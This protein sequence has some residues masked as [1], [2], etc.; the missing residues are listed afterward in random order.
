MLYTTDSETDK[1]KN[2]NETFIKILVIVKKKFGIACFHF[3]YLNKKSGRAPSK[4]Q[5]NEI[6]PTIIITLW[7][8]GMF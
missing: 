5:K 7:S 1:S 2:A 4:I 3:L 6:P 8:V